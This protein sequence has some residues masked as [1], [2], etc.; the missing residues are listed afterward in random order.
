MYDVPVYP[1]QA[2]SKWDECASQ[3]IS[4]W[5]ECVLF[6]NGI[7]VPSQFISKWDKYIYTCMY[8]MYIHMLQVYSLQCLQRGRCV[9]NMLHRGGWVDEEEYGGVPVSG[10]CGRIGGVPVSGEC[11]GIGEVPVSGECG[12]VDGGH[13]LPSP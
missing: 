9:C 5:D 13:L 6:P 2:T 10:E 3:F 1:S 4:K 8:S 11:G 7:R 12:V